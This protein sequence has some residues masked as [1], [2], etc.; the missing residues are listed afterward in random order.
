LTSVG[1][2]EVRNGFVARALW[3]HV[4]RENAAARDR[5]LEMR[6]EERAGV[7]RVQAGAGIIFDA[8]GAVLDVGDGRKNVRGLSRMALM[9]ETLGVPRAG[10]F[11]R[12][13]LIAD[14]PAAVA[15]LDHMYESL[16]V[17]VVAV[18]VA[19]EEVAVLGEHERLGIA[20][21]PR[22]EL[23]LRTIGIAAEHGTHVGGVDHAAFLRFHGGA[24]VA[25]AEV[26][27]AVGTPRQAVQIVAREIET[28]AVAAA[29]LGALLGLGLTGELPHAR[30]VGEPHLAAPGDHAGGDAVERRVETVGVH[31]AL[32]RDAVAVRVLEQADDLA[33]DPELLFALGTEF[34]PDELRAILDRAG[35]ELVLED[36]HVVADVEHAGPIAVG[37]G[38]EDPAFFVEV[39][40]DRI[41]E[42]RLGGP[43]FDLEAGGHL[44][45][46]QRLRTLIRFRRDVGR[47]FARTDV[48]DPT[49]GRRLL[50]IIVVLGRIRGAHG[51][52]EKHGGGEQGRPKSEGTFHKGEAHSRRGRG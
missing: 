38:D 52:K 48:L 13:E 31:V 47:G 30:N 23:K 40:R 10:F 27:L 18:V 37:L 24:A 11:E 8:G 32:V 49:G 25:V 1:S 34:V 28:H 20:Q 43:E 44:H 9:P 39:E 45:A 50:V 16:L 17:A 35:G 5:A 42:H 3:F 2:A 46:L 22:D 33:L 29:D 51:W 4:I 12:R 21:A 36:P 7:R 19:G 6:D 15:A 14:P 26:E 41:R